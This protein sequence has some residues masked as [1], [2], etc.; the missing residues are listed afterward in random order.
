[1]KYLRK[2]ELA[3]MPYT[4][5]KQARQIKRRCSLCL[6]ALEELVASDAEDEA[7][8]ETVQQVRNIHIGCPHCHWEGVCNAKCEWRVRNDEPVSCMDQAFSGVT[9]DEMRGAGLVWVG[10]WHDR[11]EVVV[12]KY[13][14]TRNPDQFRRE[15]DN[16][17]RFLLAHI[18]W[19]DA[20]LAMKG[21][22]RR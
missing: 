7:G 22:V 4:T 8:D 3:Q 14:Q 10:F 12:D 5:K 1:M 18:E 2:R 11:V 21:R 20:V 15:Y 17:R 9:L 13:E 19:A 6:E 16:A